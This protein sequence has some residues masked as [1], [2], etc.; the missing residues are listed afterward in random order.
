M[1]LCFDEHE[2]TRSLDKIPLGDL[3]LEN[4]LWVATKW[5][6]HY[7]GNKRGKKVMRE[8]GVEVFAV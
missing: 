6:W 2:H 5:D 8:T 1:A 3:P 7:S 4:E